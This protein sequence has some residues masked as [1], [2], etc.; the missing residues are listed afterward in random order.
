MQRPVILRAAGLAI[1]VAG[2]ALTLPGCFGRTDTPTTDNR[3]PADVSVQAA[4]LESVASSFEVGG[5]VR[6]RTTAT[7]VSRIVA[8][9]QDIP[10][11]PGD[12]VRA[13]QTLMHLDGRELQAQRKRS[14]AALAAAEQGVMAAQAARGASEASLALA[15][16]THKRISG[17][18]SRGSATPSELDQAVS[19]L[20][21]AESGMSGAQAGLRQA[22]AAADSA[23]AALQAATIDASYA[24]ITAP[25][26]GIVTETLVEVGNMASPG[27]PLMTVEDERGFR[28]EVRV[29]EA[30]ISSIDRAHPVEALLEG[31]PAGTPAGVPDTMTGIISEV[32]RTLD[33]GSHAFLVKIDLPQAGALRSGMFGRARFP[34]PSRQVLR[35]PASAVLRQGQLTSVFVAGADNRARMRLVQT[36]PVT[37][38]RIE[39][40]AGLDA[41]EP[42]IVQPPAAL[43]DGSPVRPARTVSSVESARQAEVRR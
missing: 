2:V 37:D 25:F 27:V 28:L 35:L 43:V 34:G 36:G 11:R 1:A 24:A 16:A 23:R 22:E 3:A 42:V 12:R 41:G 30:R 33:P 39:I 18:R 13:G 14:E 6:A 32:S 9:V 29:D 5:V 38:G 7:L 21:A 40:L 17:L 31:R 15:T 19:S 8:D 26:D 4:R 20:R 10:V